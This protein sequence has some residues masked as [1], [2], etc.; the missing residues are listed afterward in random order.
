[1]LEAPKISIVDDDQSVLAAMANLVQSLGYETISFQSA[2]DFLHSGRVED[3]A[4]L[5]TDI[6]MPGRSGF[7]LHQQLLADG[8][9]I[10]VIY[11]S[12]LPEFGEKC[13]KAGTVGFLT[14]PFHDESLMECLK[15]ALA[16]SRAAC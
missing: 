7:D 9:Q 1:V 16:F 8:Y 5:I 12:A 15:F 4:C 3:T 2:D 6:Q 13:L 14:K 11:M 10:P